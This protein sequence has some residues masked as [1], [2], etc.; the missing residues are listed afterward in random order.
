MADQGHIQRDVLRFRS[1]VVHELRRDRVAL[2]GYAE[3]AL[4]R[5]WKAQHF[6]WWMTSMLHVAP[7]ASDFDRRRQLGELRSVVSS[8]AGRAYLAEGYTGWPLPVG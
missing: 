2:D 4:D 8:E 5:I 1:F 3:R 7:D 6:S